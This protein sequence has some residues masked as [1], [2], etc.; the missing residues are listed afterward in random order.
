[1]AHQLLVTVAFMHQHGV[2]H[3][4][5]KPDN[6]LMRSPPGLPGV[7]VVLTDLGGAF[8]ASEVDMRRLVTEAQTL[9]YRAPEVALGCCASPVIDE[10]SM[11][12]LLAEVA[13]KRPLF[14]ASS[15]IELLQMVV[16]DLGPLPKDLVSESLLGKQ[17]DLSSLVMVPPAD[18][19]STALDAAV[20]FAVLEALLGPRARDL[21][22]AVMTL[23]TELR[24]VDPRFADLVGKLLVYDPSRRIPAQEALLHPFF[25]DI[26]IIQSLHS[27]TAAAVSCEHKRRLSVEQPAE[28][29]RQQVEAS[30]WI[31]SAGVEPK[32]AE[33]A[34]GWSS[35]SL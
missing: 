8:S 34:V 19:N 18:T 33:D 12:V 16:R 21:S 25:A 31:A 22:V 1:M 14:P 2:V 11:G 3:A 17:F 35:C 4:D 32:P 30:T 9:P 24:R 6:L 27:G 26:S 5:I 13:L 7:G 10:W 28:G 23:S 20:P 15:D 29:N